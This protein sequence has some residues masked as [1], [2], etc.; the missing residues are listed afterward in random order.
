MVNTTSAP[1]S[2]SAISSTT[3]TPVLSAAASASP[4]RSKPRTVCPAAT[5]LA[6]IGPPMFPKPIQP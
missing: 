1:A 4:E 6:A 3:V 2:T 5:R